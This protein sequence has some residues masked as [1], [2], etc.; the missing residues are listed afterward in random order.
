[1]LGAPG[2]R[3]GSANVGKGKAPGGK[4]GG[5]GGGGGLEAMLPALMAASQGQPGAGA[6]GP[7][8][9]NALAPAMGP[10]A[11][12]PPGFLMGTED[13]PAGYARGAP[14]VQP[15][16]NYP[17]GAGYLFGATAVPGQGTGAVDKVPAMLAPHEAV[18]NR[19]AADMLGRGV[20]AALNASG[21]RQMGMS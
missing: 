2:M 1:M 3:K 11:A 5:K 17:F 10:G 19:A 7:Q 9:A 6:A 4:G 21:A 20:I 14:S 18:L 15:R 13:T 12:A 16:P 8:A